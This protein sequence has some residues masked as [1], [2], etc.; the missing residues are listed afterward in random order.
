M[1]PGA[2]TYT[3][4]SIK[5]C[6]GLQI[7][8]GDSQAQRQH[9]GWTILSLFQDKESRQKKMLILSKHWKL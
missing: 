9:I 7:V 8:K 2:M 6:S 1:G 3:P 4:S 5:I